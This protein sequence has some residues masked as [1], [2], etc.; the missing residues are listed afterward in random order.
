MDAAH[1][2]RELQGALYK[3]DTCLKSHT[4]VPIA[5]L[6]PA[7]NC[8]S[9]PARHG[10][11]VP[12]FAA[13]I[14]L[15]EGPELWVIVGTDGYQENQG[16]VPEVEVNPSTIDLPRGFG[17]ISPQRCASPDQPDGNDPDISDTK[18]DPE[19]ACYETMEDLLRKYS[20]EFDLARFAYITRQLEAFRDEQSELP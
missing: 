9:W 19:T 3:Y 7:Q 12:H 11:E 16:Q 6:R 4:I 15:L 13:C 20:P 14:T 2:K 1:Q 10:T 8:S 5:Q 17:G 18:S